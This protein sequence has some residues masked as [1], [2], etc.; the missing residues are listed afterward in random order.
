MNEEPDR[1]KITGFIDELIDNLVK[2]SDEDLRVEI[3][4]SYG[5]VSTAIAGMQIEIEDAINSLNKDRL[6]EARGA[7]A[8]AKEDTSTN[9]IDPATRK[10]IF[11]L[12]SSNSS[13]IGMTLAARKNQGASESDILSA[14]TDFCELYQY[15][16][17]VPRPHFGNLP[18]AEQILRNL[19][20]TQ[21]D[22]IDVEAIAWSL[23]ARVKYEKLD[24]C[25]ARIVGADDAAIITVNSKASAERQRF[26]V[27]HE[28]GHWIY[29]RKRMLLCPADEI[30]RPSAEGMTL[31][32]VADRFASELLMPAYIFGPIAEGLGRPSMHVVRKLAE[33]FGAS[34]TATAIRLVEMSQEPMVLVC[35]GRGGR[36]WFA[37]SRTVKR[38]WFPNSDLSAETSTFNM[39]H[40]ATPQA[41]PPRSAS[42]TIW[43]SRADAPK[44]DLVEESIRVATADVL[45][46]LRFKD[47]P[48]F[49]RYAECD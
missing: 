36:R 30:E 39:I 15:T 4:E 11:E 12:L 8:K 42:A 28:I 44:F 18:K 16:H 34:Q 46:L 38:N 33:I 26:S 22:E 20:V 23:G 47:A 45:T 31:E 13:N 24:H 41:M 43:F 25:E 5:S 29:H 49:L 7:V 6:K 21:P 14:C 19:G 35:Y 3:I 9:Y 27:C 2:T 48:A 1:D 32:R 17:R 10:K 37:R 40:R